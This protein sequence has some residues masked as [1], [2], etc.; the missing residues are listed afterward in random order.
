MTPL[1]LGLG[2]LAILTVRMHHLISR[3]LI[4]RRII[5][6]TMTTM[7]AVRI[8]V[9]SM[10]ADIMTEDLTAVV[11]DIIDFVK[12]RLPNPAMEDGSKGGHV[13]FWYMHFPR[14]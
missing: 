13:F 4:A 6:V 3:L 9:G 2:S 12:S 1:V 7:P 8:M 10:V 5:T 11:A 14:P